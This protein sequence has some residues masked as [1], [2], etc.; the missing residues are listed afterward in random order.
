MKHQSFV[1][2]HSISKKFCRNLKKSLWYGIQD[3]SREVLGRSQHAEP[4][5]NEEFWALHDVSFKLSPGD[6]LGLLGRNGAG[7]TTLLRLLNGLIRPDT[8]FIKIHG[9]VT[10][11]IE[12]GTGFAPV[13]TGRENIYVNGAILGLP[14]RVVDDFMDAIIDFAEIGDFIDTPVQSY[15]E[16]MKARL[17]FAVAAHL[18]PDLMLVDEVLAVGDLGFQRK[19]LNHMTTFI[20]NGGALIFVSHNMHLIQSICERCLVL[21]AGK[22]VFDGTTPKAVEIYSTL[23]NHSNSGSDDN[24]IITLNESNPVIIDRVDIQPFEAVDIRP[25]GAIQITLYFRSLE[26]FVPVTWGFSLWTEDQEVRIATNVAKY[27]GKLH[28]LC[29]GSGNFSCV[30]KE[31]PLIPRKYCLKS[32]IYDAMTGWP[33]ARFGWEQAAAC[34]EINGEETEANSR[35]RIDQDI[36][37]LNVEWVD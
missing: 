13:L 34:F 30:V 18:V 27:D 26:E 9:R 6:A 28:R 25:G 21:D 33:I 20:R 7:K 23:N 17:G 1:E 24:K 11:L 15:S 5:R 19:C 31:L 12:L 36:V 22:M 2:V 14:G 37:N 4:L 35:H 32:G 29:S 8:G 16:G 3:I 10:P